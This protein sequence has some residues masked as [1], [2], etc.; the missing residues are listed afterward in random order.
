M[1]EHITISELSAALH[2]SETQIKESFRAVYGESVYSFART[3]KMHA[4][5]LALRESYATVLD[6]AGRFGYSNSSKFAKAFADVMGVSPS[7]YRNVSRK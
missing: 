2:A 5:A 7:E 1:D 4:A 6:I 3:M